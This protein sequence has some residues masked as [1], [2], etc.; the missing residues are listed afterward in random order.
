M[1]SKQAYFE[2]ALFSLYLNCSVK[3]L[4]DFLYICL[5]IVILD[6]HYDLRLLQ[7]L[8]WQRSNLFLR[9]KEVVKSSSLQVFTHCVDEALSDMG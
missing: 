1:H 6:Y 3:R 2:A 9:S 4:E 7:K 8:N 5:H